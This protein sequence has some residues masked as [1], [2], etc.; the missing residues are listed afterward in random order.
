MAVVNIKSGVVSKETDP[1]KARG[2]PIV[3]AGDIANT[4]TDNNGSRYLL[5]MLP[6][7]AILDARTAFQVQNWGFATVSIGTRTD[8][9]ALVQ[10]LKSAGNVVSP[11]VQFDAKHGLP[12]WQVLGLA[13]DP[14]ADIGIYA[15]AIA[16]ATGAGSMKFEIHYRFR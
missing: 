7:A 12:L 10:V 3:I 4:A 5:A 9:D 16:D 11:V 13:A 14:G 15:H 8:V 2:R 1:A 6:S